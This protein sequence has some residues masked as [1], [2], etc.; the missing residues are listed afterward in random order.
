MTAMT[1]V[2]TPASLKNAAFG[3]DNGMAFKLVCDSGSAAAQ[4][5]TL[6]FDPTYVKITDNAAPA[7]TH[8][9]FGTMPA[10]S[11][12]TTITTGVSSYSATNGVTVSAGVLTLGTGIIVASTTYY[13]RAT[14]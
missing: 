6:G 8:E 5:F 2:T 10:A 12:L 11:V 3:R 13:I 7:T 14:R 4:S 9:W 1:V